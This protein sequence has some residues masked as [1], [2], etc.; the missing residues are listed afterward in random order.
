MANKTVSIRRIL[1]P[2]DTSPLS[3]HALKTAILL[4]QQTGAE[5]FGLFVEDM[6]LLLWAELPC[7]AEVDAF[8]LSVRTVE[9]TS[10]ERQ[11]RAQAGYL[12]R[13]MGQMAQEANVPWHFE[14][15]RGSVAQEVLGASLRADLTVLGKGRTVMSPQ[16]RLGS[17]VRKVI[18]QG[19][20]ATL[21]LEYV[22][23]PLDP[24][25]VIYTGSPL[26]KQALHM[27]RWLMHDQKRRLKVLVPAEQNA[28]MER[29]RQEIHGLMADV[30]DRIQLQ[31]F[32]VRSIE[33]FV[34]LLQEEG[35]GPLVLPCDEYWLGPQLE[36]LV[37]RLPN[38]ILLV[39]QADPAPEI[40]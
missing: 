8:S 32:P 39:R 31:S 34:H 12:R 9:R 18:A 5:V 33:A 7:A 28:T 36:G 17:T 13:I 38:P 26:S 25:L 40:R 3:R 15:V 37:S 20:C 21:I 10:L 4:A 11:L 14:V 27:A 6:D 19:T 29:R 16:G 1:V 24:V 23:K 2:L 30:T 35:R 22:G